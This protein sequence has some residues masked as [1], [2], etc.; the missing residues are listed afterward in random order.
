[1]ALVRLEDAHYRSLPGGAAERL[2]APD[3]ILGGRK[4]SR[5]DQ[6]KSNNY[7]SHSFLLWNKR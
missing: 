2:P 7:A 1:M 5:G 6:E 4:S 3:A